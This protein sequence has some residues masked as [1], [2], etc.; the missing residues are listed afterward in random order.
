MNRFVSRMRVFKFFFKQN[1]SFEESKSDN[2]SSG[3]K[4]Y[5]TLVAA[6]TML[7]LRSQ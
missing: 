4:K 2:E 7:V 5:Q 6:T 1:Y 3:T